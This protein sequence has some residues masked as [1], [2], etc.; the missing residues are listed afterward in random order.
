VVDVNVNNLKKLVLRC[1]NLPK[2]VIINVKSKKVIKKLDQ[3]K[4]VA[5]RKK[6]NRNNQLFS[7]KILGVQVPGA[8]GVLQN[9]TLQKVLVGA[10]AVSVGLALVQLVNN[11]TLNKFASKKE[12]RIGTAAV[13]GDLPGAAFQFLKEDGIPKVRGAMS[14]GTIPL[15]SEQVAQREG[16]A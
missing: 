3:M 11:P 1:L 2:T 12:V 4:S 9:K 13:A 16:W 8:R 14:S 15:N 5:K 10:G 7:G 6:D